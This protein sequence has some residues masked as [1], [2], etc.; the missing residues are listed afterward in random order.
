MNK[1]E[2]VRS[3][4]E[5]I[6]NIFSSA[7]K[8]EITIF[9]TE[10]Q[11]FHSTPMYLRKKGSAVHEPFIQEVISQ[12]SVLV[13]TPGQMPSCAGCRFKNNCPSTFEISKCIKSVG[14]VIG[15]IT[16]TSFTKEGRSRINDNTET[17]LNAM[18]EISGLI[19]ICIANQSGTSLHENEDFLLKAFFD[20]SKDPLIIADSNGIILQY[21]FA[22]KNTLLLCN[23]LVTSLWHI[24]PDKI[25]NRILRDEELNNVTVNLGSY[26][27]K[28][29]TKNVYKGKRVAS[30][31][32]KM[33]DEMLSAQNG[34]FDE[35]IGT[36]EAALKVKKI[37]DKVA[38]SPTPL[39]LI[40]ETGTGKELV[41]R[42][43][44]E[45]SS[46][47]NKPFIAINC[48]SIPENLFESE[49]FGYEEGAFTGAK[50]GGKVGKIEMA[51]GGTL[52]LDELGE[53]P[54][55]FQ[56]KLL[57]IL[58][59]YELE[60]VGSLEKIPLNIRVIAAT[61]KDLTT[62]MEEGEF[63]EDLFY[64]IGVI[65]IELPPLRERKEDIIS[66]AE[67]YLIKIKG[68]INTPLRVF[69]NE[70]KE[71][72]IHY[73][74]PGNVRELQNVVEYCA[75]LCDNHMLRLDDLPDKI[76]KN[77]N[78]S[79]IDS[80][81]NVYTEE[82]IKIRDLLEQNGYT[83]ESKK[84]IAKTLGMSLRTLYRK[85]DKLKIIAMYDNED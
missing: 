20:I 43:I 71:A 80:K 82:L 29:S 17:Y 36:S 5:R 34:S 48:S 21:N 58:Q 42:S 11:I 32:I 77:N 75:N 39:L 63:R 10:S 40:G 55:M 37:I 4:I 83:L 52:F 67:N 23:K 53:M 59:E 24:F 54:L 68:N 44:H 27:V 13:N 3:S 73:A 70:S 30:Y 35:F 57:R 62:A 64:R 49:L 16:L 47:K 15:V 12:G 79:S 81:H 38:N 51:Q 9:D 56:A 76:L 65:C 41:A 28:V 60:R 84:Y 7:F 8:V 14:E 85:I 33:S 78:S 61:N 50:K 45:K 2:L 66:I 74:W 72:M 25:T 19:G 31:I 22:A 18:T 6:V 1:L 69:D 26:I 46:R